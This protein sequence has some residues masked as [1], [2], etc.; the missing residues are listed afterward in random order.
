[1]PFTLNITL[2]PFLPD[3]EAIPEKV[4]FTVDGATYE[5]LNYTATRDSNGTAHLTLL[6]K[7]SLV[8]YNVSGLY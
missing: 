5:D 6:L 7:N 2:P 8:G 1:M 4:W 3:N